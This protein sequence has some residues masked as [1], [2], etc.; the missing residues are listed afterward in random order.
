MKTYNKN[1]D[2]KYSN[3]LQNENKPVLPSFFLEDELQSEEIKKGFMSKEYTAK[4]LASLKMNAE[5]D[6][7]VQFIDKELSELEE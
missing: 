5:Q 6:D 7:F 3:N 1:K 2:I 4:L